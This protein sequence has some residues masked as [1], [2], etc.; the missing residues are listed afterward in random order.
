MS[1]APTQ[2]S[3]LCGQRATKAMGE[4]MI[5]PRLGEDFPEVPKDVLKWI[6]KVFR[7]CN[8][9]ASFKMTKIPTSQEH[10]L[11]MTIVDEVSHFSA[12]FILPSKWTVRI[13][14]HFLGGMKHFNGWEIADIG[15][16]ATFRKGGRLIKTK[17][18]LL[19]SKRL[20]PEEQTYEE[21]TKIDYMTGFGSLLEK[22]AIAMHLAQ[23][24][25]FG[26]TNKSKYSALK[27]NDDQ[28]LAIDRY[29]D[30]TKIPVYYLLYNPYEV[31]WSIELPLPSGLKIKAHAKETCK[32]LPAKIV[33]AALSG[34]ATNYTPLFSDLCHQSPMPGKK[35]W[36]GGWKLEEFVGK[37]F[38]PCK[39]GY[40]SFEARTDESI[41]N[42]FNRRSGPIASAISINIEAPITS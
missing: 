8:R 39:Q 38:I 3:G 12:P 42:V 15:L 5:Q 21:A 37:Q 22:D 14:T 35:R 31:P 25:N 10:S 4:Q 33:R 40:K 11:D 26:F 13:E 28:Y 34:K 29:E 23:P 18:A 6:I 41:Y 1:G 30:E 17:V 19:Q 20:Y 24:R 32:V 36:P 9:R 27:V 7:I 16:L 2:A